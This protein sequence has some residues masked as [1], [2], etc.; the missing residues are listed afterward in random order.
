M[1][2]KMEK[3]FIDFPLN[4]QED[5]LCAVYKQ[6]VLENPYTNPHFCNHIENPALRAANSSLFIPTAVNNYIKDNRE[7]F[8][9][10]IPIE[11][12][13]SLESAGDYVSLTRGWEECDR[14]KVMSGIMKKIEETYPG[15]DI[16]EASRNSKKGGA[17]PYGAEWDSYKSWDIQNYIE[18]E[19]YIFIK[20][21]TGIY[22]F[23]YENNVGG[24]LSKLDGFFRSRGPHQICNLVQNPT[25]VWFT[26]IG[27]YI[28]GQCYCCKTPLNLTGPWEAGHIISHAD[29]GPDTADNLRPTCVSCNRSMGTENMDAFKA[30]CYP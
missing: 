14:D 19:R 16:E 2:V 25:Q 18:I 1:S 22:K 4:I 20:I 15:I 30:R 13:N 3:I 17:K 7:L 5:I 9:H 6:K 21:Y 10:N 26:H 12:V 11:V 29:G 28:N 24:Q 23:I 27:Y 8:I